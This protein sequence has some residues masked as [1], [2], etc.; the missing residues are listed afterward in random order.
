MRLRLRLR[1]RPD[2]Q[3]PFAVPADADPELARTIPR[4]RPWPETENYTCGSGTLW[5]LNRSGLLM[6]AARRQL[7]RD[8][9]DPTELVDGDVT[10]SRIVAWEVISQ[11]QLDGLRLQPH[12]KPKPGEVLGRR[13]DLIRRDG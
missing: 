9:R 1:R 6:K 4:H 3:E 2:P 5:H 8:G 12:R 7:A 10:I 11:A 13:P